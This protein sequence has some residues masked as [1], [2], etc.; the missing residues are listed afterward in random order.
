M[1]IFIVVA[2]GLSCFKSLAVYFKLFKPD[3]FTTFPFS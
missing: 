1:V 2:S 3:V